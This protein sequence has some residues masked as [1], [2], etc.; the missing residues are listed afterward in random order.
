MDPFYL[1]KQEIEID[2]EHIEELADTRDDMIHDPRGIN[3]EVFNNIELQ[4]ANEITTVNG[5]IKDTNEAIQQ[6]RDNPSEFPQVTST[7]LSQR[8]SFCS[9]IKD[10]VHK[11]EK[12]I[13]DQASHVTSKSSYFQPTS[14]NPRADDTLSRN[15][16]E[17]AIEHD[18]QRLENLIVEVQNQLEMAKNVKQEIDDQEPILLDLNENI[19]SASEAMQNVTRQINQ[20][21][22]NEGKVPTTIAFVLAIILIILIFIAA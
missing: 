6:V 11:I 10:R 22:E 8:S 15:N 5:L 9:E 12:K 2:M 18:D 4:I 16:L 3:I 19:D 21:L 20:F 17:L 7:E 14:L 13:K 1:I